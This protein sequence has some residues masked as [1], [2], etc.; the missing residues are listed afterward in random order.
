M[1]VTKR[2]TW[3]CKTNVFLLLVHVANLE[4]DVFFAQWAR[5]I[6]DDVTEALFVN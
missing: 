5:R 6:V 3:W 1:S 4:P 2:C